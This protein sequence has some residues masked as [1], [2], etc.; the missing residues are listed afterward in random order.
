MVAFGWI[1]TRAANPDTDE[2]SDLGDVAGRYGTRTKIKQRVE[3]LKWER[4]IWWH[5]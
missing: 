5:R 2:E 3:W 1:G 4:Q